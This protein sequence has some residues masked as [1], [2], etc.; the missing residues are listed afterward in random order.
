MVS[1]HALARSA[2]RFLKPYASLVQ[3]SIHAL[4]R[5]ANYEPGN[6]IDLLTVSIHALARSANS[7]WCIICLHFIRFNPRARTEREFPVR[8]NFSFAPVSIHA[9]ARSAKPGRLLILSTREVSIHALARSAN[10]SFPLPS[11]FMIVSI[12]ALARS[13]N[14]SIYYYEFK[15][16]LSLISLIIYCMEN[17]SYLEK[18]SQRK[19][20]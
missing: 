7:R 16:F 18:I 4:A 5:S 11:L 10:A 13:A 2:K 14:G 6:D 15:N 8:C 12:H 9:L 1:I 17:D 20:V 19:N 3:V